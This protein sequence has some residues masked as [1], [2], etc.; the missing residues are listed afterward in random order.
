MTFTPGSPF[1]GQSL[2]SSKPQV[3]GNFAN[4]FSVISQDHVD[5]NASGQGKHNKSTYVSQTASPGTLSTEI[6]AYSK[7]VAG[8]VEWF[9][10]RSGQMAAGPDIQLTSSSPISGGSFP[11]SGQTFLAGGLQ[12]KW[13]T[14][15][16]SAGGSS[17]PTFISQG[18]PNFPTRGLIGFASAWSNPSQF[19]ITNVT[20][21]SI[22]I[23][24]PGGG[25]CFWFAIGN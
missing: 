2:G 10:Q 23:A 11:S 13:G 6:A 8:A 17:S 9:L 15:S 1:D 5:P 24:S 25:S 4:Y 18:L 19:N 22:T 20:Q 14:A 21:T 16:V 3:R 7:T 12:L